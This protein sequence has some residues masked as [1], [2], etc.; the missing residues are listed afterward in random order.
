MP[1]K[2]RIIEISGQKYLIIMVGLL[3]KNKEKESNHV[4]I[5]F[6]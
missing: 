4:K 5:I 6:V 2:Y 1:E 3:Y